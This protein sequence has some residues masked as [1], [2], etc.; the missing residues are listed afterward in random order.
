[1]NVKGVLSDSKAVDIQIRDI[2]LSRIWGVLGVYFCIYDDYSFNI[3]RTPKYYE[4]NFHASK[5]GGRSGRG[6]KT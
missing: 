3:I 4:L 2:S 1:M 5:D 6:F